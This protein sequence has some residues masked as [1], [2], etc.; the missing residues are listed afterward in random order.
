MVQDPTDRKRRR[1]AWEQSLDEAQQWQVYD[2]MRKF[3]WVEVAKWIE[4]QFHIEPPSR[5]ALYRFCEY[6]RDHEAEFMLRQRIHDREA[7]D[8]ELKTAG[9]VESAKLVQAL[10]NDV[11]AAR[12]KG[13]DMAVERAVRTYCA[14][15]KVV[16]DSRAFALAHQKFEVEVCEKF[17]A[18]FHDA[19]A[20][21]IAESQATNSD[22]IA[23]LRQAYYAD[24]DALEKSGE[25]QL[26]Q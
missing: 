21:A 13:D 9:A 8:R 23:A 11:A 3:S 2:R 6:A 14:V 4:A 5:A 25:V 20:K 7:L 19:K 12:S 24:V 18:W 22:K 17:L 15:A 10:G 26:P 1:D 16:G